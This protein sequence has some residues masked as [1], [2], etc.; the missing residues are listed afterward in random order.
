MS[1]LKQIYKTAVRGGMEAMELTIEADIQGRV[2]LKEAGGEAD[3]E[4]FDADVAEAERVTELVKAVSAAQDT[5]V[6][7]DDARDI[8]EGLESLVAAL[9]G[10]NAAGGVPLPAFA[11][12]QQAA[13]RY[14]ARLNLDIPLVNAAME[15]F[16]GDKNGRATVSVAGLEALINKLEASQPALARQSQETM[17]DMVKALRDALPAA[18]ERLNQLRGDIEMATADPTGDVSIDASTC[19]ALFVNGSLPEDLTAYFTSYSQLGCTLFNEYSRVA[20]KSAEQTAGLV[21]RLDFNSPEGFWASLDRATSAIQDPRTTLSSDIIGLTLPGGGPLFEGPCEDEQQGNDVFSR[22]RVFVTGYAPIIQADVNI[23]EVEPAVAQDE[24][25]VPGTEG[26][27]GGLIGFL[28]GGMGWAPFLGPAVHAIV[29]AKRMKMRQDIQDLAK[30]IAMVRNGQVDEV[31]KQG[32]TKLPDKLRHVDWIEILKSAILGQWFGSFYGIRQGSQLEDLNKE[33]RAKL[34]ELNAEL[35]AAGVSSLESISGEELDAL[36][37]AEEVDASAETESEDDIETGA[38]IKALSRAQLRAI[39][40]QLKCLLCDESV[41]KSLSSI[42]ASWGPSEAALGE[43]RAAMSAVT[44]SVPEALGG[45]L[46]IVDRYIETL[47]R[48]S[49]WP[50]VNYLANLIYTVNAFVA[51]GSQML[52]ADSVEVE[53]EAAVAAADAT[54]EAVEVTVDPETESVDVGTP[55]DG[56]AAAAGIS[57]ATA[58]AAEEGAA[59]AVAAGAANDVGTPALDAGDALNPQDAD[60]GTGDDLGGD[61]G[62]DTGEGGDLGG[63]P[64][65][66]GE[67]QPGP[68]DVDEEGDQT[69]ENADE[70]PADDESEEQV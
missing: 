45:R 3:V 26:W 30:R 58:E 70:P 25:L 34:D 38:T 59:D 41:E 64:E 5:A 52:H 20:Q 36:P 27:K 62:G 16:G 46:Q 2:A 42:A 21:G 6:L 40:E 15:S 68:L 48:L 19:N 31:V 14:A 49:I 37:S 29:K 54:D 69:D 8:Q 10:M 60:A 7:A 18:E 50:Q 39:T 24:E 57:D 55:D 65:G 12:A 47:H 53:D 61:V 43:A 67:T 23:G 4:A 1:K 28:V 33:L 44:G 56:D 63:V 11:L 32:G 22:L 9:E 66:E 17:S 51:F 35:E 13:D